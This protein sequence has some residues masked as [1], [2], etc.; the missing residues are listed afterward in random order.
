MENRNIGLSLFIFLAGLLFGL[1]TSYNSWDGIFFVYTGSADHRQPAAINKIF[2]YSHLEGT[3]L[4]LA[5]QERLVESAKVEV[6]DR[7]VGIAL[8]HFVTKSDQGR[9][10]LACQRYSKLELEFIA[11]GIAVNGL[12]P[13]MIVESPCHE[14]DQDINRMAT[15]W[16]PLGE[17]YASAPSDNFEQQ[18][19]NNL[20]VTL[21]MENLGGQWPDK[22]VLNSVQLKGEMDDLT[23]SKDD[24]RLLPKNVEFTVPR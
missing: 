22:W 5:A 9:K 10:I 12:P 21:R 17:L 16:L 6:S 19:F 23:I 7:Q 20:P 3:A 1:S 8:G 11:P 2:D 14:N 24:I 4:K 13:K 18:Y 15:I